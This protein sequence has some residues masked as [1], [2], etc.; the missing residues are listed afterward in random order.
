MN[1]GDP[2][3]PTHDE[4]QQRYAVVLDQIAEQEERLE[5]LLGDML[6]STRHAVNLPWHTRELRA[7][8]PPRS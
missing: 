8:R 7:P 2:G 1:L 3:A 4:Q 5:R 6:M